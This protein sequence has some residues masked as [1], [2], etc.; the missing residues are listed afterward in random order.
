MRFMGKTSMM[1]FLWYSRVK[2]HKQVVGN[3]AALIVKAAP[4]MGREK[5]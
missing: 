3:K 2:T 4:F 5:I 1:G